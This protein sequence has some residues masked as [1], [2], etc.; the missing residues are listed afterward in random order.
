M[1]TEQLIDQILSNNPRVSKDEI[2]ERLEKEK[3]RTNGLILEETLLRM[4]A[5]DLGIKI[6]NNNASTPALSIQDLVPSLDH[7]T[8]VGRVIATFPSRAFNGR[9]SG[10]FASFLI[11]DKT[12]ILRIVLWNDKTSLI[13][14]AEIKVGQMVRISNGYTKEDSRGKVELHISEK[15]K[16]EINPQNVEEKDYPTASKFVTKISQITHAHKNNKINVMGKVKKQFSTSTFERQ[17]SSVGKVTRIV[18]ADETGEISTVVWNEKVDELEENLKKG[19]KLQILDAKVK[20]TLNEGLEIH[21]DSSTYMELLTPTEEFAKITDLQLGSDNVNVEGQVISKPVIRE[22]KTSKEELVKLASFELTDET[23]RIWV[24]TWRKH[25]ETIKD[26]KVGDRIMIKDAYVKRGFSDQ[27]EI[28]TR[29][30]SSVII[31]H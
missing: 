10:R 2:M 8:I 27:L 11:A 9:R 6:Q 4:I 7:A 17:D 14:S 13:D 21:I 16:V 19:V 20:K 29:E 26:L 15:C 18:L 30:C 23:G 25:A 22:I 12:G 31:V 28:S 24:S 3:R 1:T 5:V